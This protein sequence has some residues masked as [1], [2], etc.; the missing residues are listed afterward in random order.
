MTGR[1]AQRWQALTTIAVAGLLLVFGGVLVHSA[2]AAAGV[3][4]A[5]AGSLQTGQHGPAAVVP[6]AGSLGAP[7]TSVDTFAGLGVAGLL[8]AALLFLG[9]GAAGGGDSRDAGPGGRRRVRGPP[10]RLRTAS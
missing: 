2:A 4:G 1:P 7:Y 3:G 9:R 5:G 10:R 6:H 8:S